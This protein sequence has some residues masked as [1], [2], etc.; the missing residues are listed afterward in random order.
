MDI[1]TWILEGKDSGTHSNNSSQSRV[2]VDGTST[3][4]SR[5]RG[6]CG[7]RESASDGRGGDS[8]SGG[9]GSG[10]RGGCH[11]AHGHILA[12][13]VGDYLG[14]TQQKTR[15]VRSSALIISNGSLSSFFSF[16]VHYV[17]LIAYLPWKVLMRATWEAAVTAPPVGMQ[18]HTT[19]Y[20]WQTFTLKLDL[21]F[22]FA[23][24]FTPQTVS[25][26]FEQL[27]AKALHQRVAGG[28][29]VWAETEARRA[30]VAARM[31]DEEVF[32]M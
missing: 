8:R 3:G 14:Q 28:S 2:A 1:Q 12:C 9:W 16:L 10:D 13:T 30:R 6:R 21:Q 7:C 31:M 24:R 4:T 32:M 20:D 22:H 23:S 29:A 11:L 17:G 25:A 26:A 15:G 18:L 5:S 19:S 27:A